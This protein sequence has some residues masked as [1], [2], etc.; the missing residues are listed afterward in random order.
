MEN[1]MN[2]TE[3]QNQQFNDIPQNQN[4]SS[5]TM[6]NQNNYNV[7]NNHNE[8]TSF[9]QMVEYSRGTIV[10][11]PDFGEG[12]PFI[13]RVRRPSLLIMAKEGKIPNSLLSTAGELFAE[14]GKSLSS[15]DENMLTDM[16]GVCEVLARATLIS[17]TYEEILSAG[18]NLTDEQMLAIFN[19]TQN[20]VKALEPFR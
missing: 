2:V 5:I 9:Q 13:A 20:G 1:N 12:Q 7:T 14:G 4:I 16:Y 18:M 10:R 17:P 11:L 3:M 15:G 8:T 19:Y 6:E